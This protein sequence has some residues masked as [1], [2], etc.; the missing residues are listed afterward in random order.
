M[1]ERVDRA[2]AQVGRDAL[3]A[4]ELADELRRDA[5]VIRDRVDGFVVVTAP[6]VGQ[7]SSE[8]GMTPGPLGLGQR[9]VGD[10]A[11]ELGLEREFPVF[12]NHEVTIGEG[13]QRPF[14]P[15]DRLGIAQPDDGF[16]GAARSDD[17]AVLEHGAINGR[18]RVEPSRDQ[19]AQGD[20]QVARIERAGA[21][22][23]DGAVGVADERGELL[24][25]QRVAAAA[26]PE[27]GHELGGRVLLEMRFDERGG[28]VGV[29]R[30]EVEHGGVVTTGRR[31]PMLLELGTGCGDEH[32]G[33][34]AQR[35]EEPVDELEHDLV[36]P[37]QIGEDEHERPCARERLEVRLHRPQGLAARS[38]RVDVGAFAESAEQVQEAVGDALDVGVVRITGRHA[39]DRRLDLPAGVVR[40]VIEIDPAR[41]PDGLGNRPPHVGLAVRETWRLEHRGAALLV[42]HRRE[43][44]RQP[45][46][47]DARFAEQQHELRTL[48]VQCRVQHP[49]QQRHLGIAPDE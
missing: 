31:C 19:A 35:G 3:D 42:R 23:P 16:D 49:A 14:G 1:L 12:E 48:A 41:V 11:D 37:V 7:P 39:G 47:A 9:A 28:G 40:G 22:G 38:R 44:D 46:L 13:R 20:G 29:E 25:E 27:L 5:E 21:I 15:G 34:R 4:T 32:E 43:L 45:A 18:E 26:V 2:G 30:I 6:T 8:G 10:L 36:A 33:K 17:R 24:D